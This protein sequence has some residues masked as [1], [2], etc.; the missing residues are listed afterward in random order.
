MKRTINLTLTL[1]VILGVSFMFSGCGSS[2]DVAKKKE[3]YEKVKIYCSGAEYE[4]SDG[5]MRAN[6]SGSSNDMEIAR[7]K[8][9]TN[10]RNRLSEQLEVMVSN[11]T[12]YYKKETDYLENSSMEKRFE[13]LIREVSEN[14]LQG[15][16]PICEEVT[17]N[18]E[19]HYIAYAAVELGGDEYVENAANRLSRDEELKVDYDYEKFKDSYKKAMEDLEED[20]NN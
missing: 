2:K 13:D 4:S 12:D 16:L 19:G 5:V 10:A 15:V 9:L 18:D 17:Q 6:A 7:D 8:A 11:L 1:A 14:K 20:R 3:G